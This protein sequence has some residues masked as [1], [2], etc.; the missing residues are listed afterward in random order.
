MGAYNCMATIERSL[1]GCNN[2]C[3][4]TSMFQHEVTDPGILKGGGGGGGGGGV[5]WQQPLTY[6]NF[7]CRI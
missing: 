6:G 5:Q 4:D 2:C 1:C 7:Y 3:K